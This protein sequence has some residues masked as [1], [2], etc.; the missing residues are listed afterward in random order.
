MIR[1]VLPA[2]LRRLAK[3][4]GPVLLEVQGPPTQ[5]HLL[6]ALERR[7]PMLRGCTRD[8]QS[9]KRRAY[10]RF[11]ACGLDLSD[12]APDDPLPEAVAA[13]R[14]PYLVVGALSGG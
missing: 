14:E 9:K 3:Y 2:P 13:G 10:V 11:Y 1:V 6:D 12:A 8:Q 7:F 5:R 4:D